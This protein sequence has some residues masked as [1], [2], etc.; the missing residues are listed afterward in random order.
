MSRIYFQIFLYSIILSG[1]KLSGQIS[2]LTIDDNSSFPLK[3]GDNG[4]CFQ[5]FTE[6]CGDLSAFLKIDNSTYELFSKR[7]EF[8]GKGF[9]P[10]TPEYISEYFCR[11]IVPQSLELNLSSVTCITDKYYQKR[12]ALRTIIDAPYGCRS[13]ELPSEPDLF[14]TNLVIRKVNGFA[15]AGLI[16]GIGFCIGGLSMGS[17]T[18]DGNSSEAAEDN[19]SF[20]FVAAGVILS[21]ISYP[22]LHKLVPDD[23]QNALNTDYNDDLVYNWQRE[24]QRIE[25]LNNKVINTFNVRIYIK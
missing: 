18:S 11:D 25:E 10:I 24:R 3:P 7:R 23:V 21:L 9:I 17:S 13:F 14:P 2:Y 22:N 8:Y 19:K 20:Y 5:Y 1:L 12:L 15:V 4:I 16:T 6:K